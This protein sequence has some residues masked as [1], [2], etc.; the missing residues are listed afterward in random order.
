[1]P[2]GFFMGRVERIL[3]E[4]ATITVEITADDI[5]LVSSKIPNRK[6]DDYSVGDEVMISWLPEKATVFEV[7]PEGIEDEL[8][9]D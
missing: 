3:Y 2:E 8:R 7:P 5:G 9:L 1:M 6:F 4:G